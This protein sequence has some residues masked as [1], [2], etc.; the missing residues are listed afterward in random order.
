MSLAEQ[1]RERWVFIQLIFKQFSVQ[2]KKHTMNLKKLSKMLQLHKATSGKA[3]RS[4][5]DNF[6]IPETATQSSWQHFITVI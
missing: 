6:P 4:S 1:R 5:S 3:F 2:V